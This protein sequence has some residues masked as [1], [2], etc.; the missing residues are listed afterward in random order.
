LDPHSHVLYV[1][2][3]GNHLIRKVDLASGLVSTVCGNG[4]QGNRD[5][6]FR[7]HQ[8]LDSPFALSFSEPHYLLISCADNSLRKFNMKSGR[9]E[10]VLIGS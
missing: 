2:D 1:A 4:V 7:G 5:S 8:C 3:C 9:L 10:T 6:G